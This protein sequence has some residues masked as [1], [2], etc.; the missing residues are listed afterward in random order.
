MLINLN[1]QIKI[2]SLHSCQ[3]NTI[4]A[5]QTINVIFHLLSSGLCTL[6]GLILFSIY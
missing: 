4:K 6:D 2:I 5:S 1:G 3:G